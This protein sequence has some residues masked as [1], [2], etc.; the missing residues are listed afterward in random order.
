MHYRLWKMIMK[1]KG[2]TLVELLVVIAIIGILVALLLPAV[3]AAREAAR[4]TQCKNKMKQLGL[5]LLTYQE[6]RRVFPP[7][8][9]HSSP[10][11]CAGSKNGGPPWSV[12]VLSFIEQGNVQAGFDASG[13]MTS[14]LNV[15]GT[16]RNHEV[17]LKPN[18]DYQCPSDPNSRSDINNSN[19]FGVQGGGNGAEGA[20]N[21]PVCT[22]VSGQ[23]VFYNNGVLYHNS[24]IRPKDIT[25]GLSKTFL[26][27]ETKYQRTRESSD[28]SHLGWASSSNSS[29]A[30][31]RP[32]VLAAALLPIN[33]ELNHG[34]TPD[35]PPDN[36]NALNYYTRLFGSFHVE[37]CHFV[38][39][40]GSVHY[41][42]D[43][44]N[45]ATYYYHAQRNDGK[46]L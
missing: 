3:N 7:G 30:S 5:A 17:W 31:G 21:G 20:K 13:D 43:N 1:R 33:N 8:Y 36:W 26:M 4:R 2:F 45:L 24:K 38:M 42:S 37:G 35:A 40:D 11:P 25:D 39:C 41:I 32:G 6:S 19:Y 16:A 22:T 28:T 29:G 34:A 9:N 27:G 15:P 12:L 14:T 23:R 46:A 18:R 44:I 10:A